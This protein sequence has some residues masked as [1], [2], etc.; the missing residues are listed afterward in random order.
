MI[1]SIQKLSYWQ[2]EKD[3]WEEQVRTD[4]EGKYYRSQGCTQSP[5]NPEIYNCPIGTPDYVTRNPDGT[6]HAD[7]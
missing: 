6:I 4:A 5:T 2:S 7:P 3:F 1:I